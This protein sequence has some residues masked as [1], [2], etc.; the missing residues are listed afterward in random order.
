[1]RNPEVRGQGFREDV[2][3]LLTPLTSDGERVLCVLLET[4]HEVH[5]ATL[6]LVVVGVLGR[7]VAPGRELIVLGTAGDRSSGNLDDV[8][9]LVQVLLTAGDS[10]STLI[11]VLTG[12]GE[13]V[14]DIVAYGN[15][16]R[17]VQL[18]VTSEYLWRVVADAD[19]G[20]CVSLVT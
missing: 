3:T 16:E 14:N 20:A 11:G 6:E 10:N 9:L 15:A 13:D 18:L 19:C 7:T 8:T 4:S 1:M 17:R 2:K 12:Y 5:A